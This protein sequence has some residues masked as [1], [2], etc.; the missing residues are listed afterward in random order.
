MI[1]KLLSKQ[2]YWITSGEEKSNFRVINERESERKACLIICALPLRT[3]NCN[4][5]G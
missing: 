1:Q 2:Y 5:F 3:E 4:L